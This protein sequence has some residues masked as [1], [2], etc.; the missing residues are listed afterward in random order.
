MVAVVVVVMVVET[1]EGAGLATRAGFGE[2]F[3]YRM[4]FQ[5]TSWPLA[6]MRASTSAFWS[7]LSSPGARTENNDRSR[8]QVVRSSHFAG[9]LAVM[10]SFEEAED[11]DG[12][13]ID[14]GEQVYIL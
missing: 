8:S 4:P 5:L 11:K 6:R 13:W 12:R 10:A 14:E 3:A 1:G 9:I 7:A 2:I